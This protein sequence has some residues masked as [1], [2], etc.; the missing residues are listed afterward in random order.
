MRPR[1]GFRALQ[2]VG[3]QRAGVVDV[4]VDLAG[5]ERAK[6]DRR[7]EIVRSLA[8]W[9]VPPAGGRRSA[10]PGCTARRSSWRRPHS[11]RRS[12]GRGQR[13]SGRQRPGEQQAD[14]DA[15]RGRGWRRAT[16]G[17]IRPSSWSVTAS[18][19][20]A[21]G[22]AAEQHQ[23]PVLGLQAGE[24]VVA[25]AVWPTG[26]ARVAAPI[27]QTA[28]VRTPAMITGAA[29]G[30]STC[31]SRWRSVMPTPRAASTMAG[32]TPMMPATPFRRIGSIE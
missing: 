6:G 27:V 32:S 24:D 11:R 3:P 15:T 26:V 12:R 21:G 20:A 14:A 29:S 8:G 18:A 22:A 17:S 31:K 9:P 28:A 4:D 16:A 1:Q 7:A 23:H 30:S 25:E 2:D 5:G 19:S 13:P 10:R